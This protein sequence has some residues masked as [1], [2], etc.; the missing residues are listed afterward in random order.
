MKLWVKILLALFIIAVI[1]AFY[2]YKYATGLSAAV[3]LAQK[4]L[5]GGPS[6]LEAYLGF[7]KSGGTKFPLP[8]LAAAGVDISG[9]TPIERTLSLFASRVNELETLLK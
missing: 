2:V 3:S 7:L 9:P 4:V 8:T 6:D 1:A 5:K